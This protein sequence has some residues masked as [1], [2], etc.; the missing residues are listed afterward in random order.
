MPVEKPM[1]RTHLLPEIF[2]I[3]PGQEKEGSHVEMTKDGQHI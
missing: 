3:R 1:T 2:M